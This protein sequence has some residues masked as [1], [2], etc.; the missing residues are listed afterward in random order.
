VSD[1]EAESEDEALGED[2]ASDS[3]GLGA[4]GDLVRLKNKRLRVARRPLVLMVDCTFISKN[5]TIS[6]K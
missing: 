3:E 5:H 4:L 1:S 2:E 6:N